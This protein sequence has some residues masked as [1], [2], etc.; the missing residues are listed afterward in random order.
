MQIERATEIYAGEKPST[1][2]R[3][4]RNAFDAATYP[5]SWTRSAHEYAQLYVAALY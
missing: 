1:Y 4:L 2:A 5:Y 3:L